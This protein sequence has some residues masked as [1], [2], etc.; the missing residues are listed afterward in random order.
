MS[1]KVVVVNAGKMDF[2]GQLDFSIL[3]K[4]GAT[5]SLLLSYP[6]TCS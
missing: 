3:S 6:P 4:M 2:D 5:V 1:Q